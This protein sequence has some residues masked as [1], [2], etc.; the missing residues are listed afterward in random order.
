MIGFTRTARPV[1][2]PLLL[3]GVLSLAGCGRRGWDTKWSSIINDESL[4]SEQLIEAVEAFL[5]EDPPLKYAS[6][7]R[8]T[9]GFTWAEGL[10]RYGEARRWFEELLEKDPKCEWADDAEWMLENMEKDVDELLPHLREDI[11]PPP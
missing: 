3:L 2:F 1:V 8:F 9:I 10:H 6:Q 7:A 4:G 11:P 5:A